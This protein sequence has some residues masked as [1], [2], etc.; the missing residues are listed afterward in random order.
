[1]LY[2]QYLNLLKK[3]GIILYPIC[4]SGKQMHSSLGDTGQSSTQEE[5]TEPMSFLTMPHCLLYGINTDG[6]GHLDLVV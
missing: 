2:M 3:A 1:M 4:Q 5:T 6:L